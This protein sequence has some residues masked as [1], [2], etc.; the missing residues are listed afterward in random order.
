VNRRP[1]NNFR[2]A[3]NE[4][5]IKEI[6]L[7]GW[8]YTWSSGTATP[9]MTKIDHIFATREWELAYPHYHLQALSSSVS[10]HCS[11]LLT[12]TPFQRKYKGFRF[13]MCCLSLPGFM[14]LVNQSWTA[15]V[16]AGNKARLLHI[17]LS[18]LAKDLRKWNKQ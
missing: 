12:C 5:E 2:S 16:L 11:M 15:L 13:E 4:L 14:D 8:K 3:I 1:M 18:R 10:D 9:T 7:Q 6:H 17:K